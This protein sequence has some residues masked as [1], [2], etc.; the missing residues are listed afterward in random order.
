MAYS[1]IAVA[2]AFIKKGNEAGLTDLSPMKLQKLVF[3]AHSWNLK[4]YEQPLVED[5]FAKWPYGPVIPELYRTT[6]PYGNAHISSSI[7]TIEYSGGWKS[8]VVTPIIEDAGAELTCLL[9]NIFKVYGRMSA[10]KLSALTHRPG[11][12]WAKAGENK[13]VLDNELLKEGISIEEKRFMSIAEFPFNF[14][15]ARMEKRIHDESVIVP[16]NLES[17][18]DFDNWLKK[19]IKN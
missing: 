9:D 10:A 14:N 19:V 2:N 17:L 5:F 16:D 15:L 12:A 1:A 8:S 3:F 6:R 18:D 4:L 11:S 13:T 7:S